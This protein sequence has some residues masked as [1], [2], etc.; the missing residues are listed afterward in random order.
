[1]GPRIKGGETPPIGPRVQHSR[2][3]VQRIH[4]V[5]VMHQTHTIT[6]GGGEGLREEGEGGGEE[7]EEIKGTGWGLSVCLSVRQCGVIWALY[8]VYIFKKEM[9]SGAWGSYRESCPRVPAP[10]LALFLMHQHQHRATSTTH[11]S[12]H[13][14]NTNTIATSTRQAVTLYAQSHHNIHSKC[15]LLL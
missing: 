9:L 15:A 10:A 12:H 8:M 13:N 1:M 5:P 6:Q 14:V 11:T 2:G 3:M 7:G 4:V